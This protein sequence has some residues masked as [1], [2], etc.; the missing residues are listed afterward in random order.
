LHGG[1][2]WLEKYGAKLRKIAILKSKSCLVK[3]KYFFEKFSKYLLPYP[4]VA[5]I[6]TIQNIVL[7]T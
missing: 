1:G 6:K 4:L 5:K 3:V 2:V 7:K